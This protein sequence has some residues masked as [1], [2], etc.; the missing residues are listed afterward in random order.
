MT[1]AQTLRTAAFRAW[2]RV[3]RP[4][5]LGVRGVVTDGDG[6]VLLVRHTYVDG[7]FFPGGGVERGEPARE[8]LRREL[9]EE[10]GVRPGVPGE[11][12]GVYSNHHAFRNDHVLLY[13]VK[14]WVPVQPNNGGEIAEI[15]W[16]DPLRPPDG[17]T[18]GTARRLAELFG[19]GD[20]SDYW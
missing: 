6:R 4:M 15:V 7:L 1:L 9:E 16:C 2:F 17:V 10:A 19:A 12:V 14:D 3:S 13:L 20:R 11:L 18:A 8:A 5:T